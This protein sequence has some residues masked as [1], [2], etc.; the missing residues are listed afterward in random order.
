MYKRQGIDLKMLTVDNIVT[1]TAIAN[2]L[3]ILDNGHIAVEAGRLEKA[4][5]EELAQMLPGIR[6][7]AR[8]TPAVKMRVVNALKKMGNVVAVTGDGINDAPAIKNAD[9]GIAMGISG[10]EV[11]KERCV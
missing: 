3:G 5:D 1:A 11:S 6:V 7:I 8:S 10:T 4:T 9:V 2:D